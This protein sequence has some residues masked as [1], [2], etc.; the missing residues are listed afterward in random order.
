MD[1]SAPSLDQ[2]RQ[3]LSL[4]GS[5]ADLLQFDEM[6]DR[7]PL[8]NGSVDYVHCSSVLHDVP[9]PVRVMSEFRCILRPGGRVRLMIYNYDSVWLH[10][11]APLSPLCEAAGGCGTI[12]Q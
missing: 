6:D 10:L 8:E 3:R 12:A 11:F 7:L 2:A 4:R 5:H 1:V 9:D